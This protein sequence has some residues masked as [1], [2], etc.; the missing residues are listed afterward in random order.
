MIGEGAVKVVATGFVTMSRA[1]TGLKSSRFFFG[2]GFVKP[3]AFPA[4]G[5]SCFGI[6]LEGLNGIFIAEV[7]LLPFLGES[8]CVVFYSV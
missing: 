1:G 2:E 3:V 5:S 4:A 8:A 7:L 6:E